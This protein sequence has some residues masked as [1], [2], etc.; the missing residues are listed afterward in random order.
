MRYKVRISVN[1]KRQVRSFKTE[2][3]AQAFIDYMLA[4]RT[5]QVRGNRFLS[6]DKS[7][8]PIGTPVGRLVQE[9]LDYCREHQT[10]ARSSIKAYRNASAYF[11][12]IESKLLCD[13]SRDDFMKV[14]V[15]T[16]EAAPSQV[17]NLFA[18]LNG[19]YDFMDD[20]DKQKIYGGLDAN[21]LPF[22]LKDEKLKV[23][24]PKVEEKVSFLLL[25]EFIL[26][27][28]LCVEAV[29]QR[30]P[31]FSRKIP[32][33][34]K[35][36]GMSGIRDG[37]IVV[38]PWSNINWTQK[39]IRVENTVQ[40]NDKENE[41]DPHVIIFEGTKSGYQYKR[42][43]KVDDEVMEELRWFYEE[44]KRFN[45]K[46]KCNNPYVITA[47]RLTVG[48]G[49]DKGPEEPMDVSSI[50]AYYAAIRALLDEK[51]VSL[52]YCSLNPQDREHLSPHTMR[53]TYGM[54]FVES[55]NESGASLFDLKDNMGHA[56]LDST[57]RYL[58]ARD[59][60][61]QASAIVMGR[62]FKDGLNAATGTANVASP[63][64]RIPQ[65]TNYGRARAKSQRR[66]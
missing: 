60:K 1:G 9:Y 45:E 66:R 17:I 61:K 38:L 3:E 48:R 37:E 22:S 52:Q 53:H 59:D 5:P 51:G 41:D 18:I 10:L 21:R 49:G 42:T 64:A 20:K 6:G 55:M 11:K 36:L 8:G 25:E 27:H 19:I 65:I 63:L 43:I 24:R 29:E 14:L 50:R 15:K 56:G 58:H 54:L 39:T 40:T 46:Y 13:V 4:Q 26:S 31:L 47:D 12:P 35:L 28:K 32:H 44:N 2:P 16:R 34:H 7:S 33:L 23:Y 30:R 57:A 62:M